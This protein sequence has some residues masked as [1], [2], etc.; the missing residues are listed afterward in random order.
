MIIRPG[1]YETYWQ[2]AANRQEIFFNRLK[3]NAPPW[4]SDPILNTY[5][6]CNTYRASDRVSQYLIRNVIYSGD[7]DAQEVILRTLL[8]KL[9]NKIETWEYLVSK[10]G[11][12]S[13]KN[14]DFELYSSLLNEYR[15]AD[16][17]IYHN[18]YMSC[19]TKAF[20]YDLKHMNHLALVEKMIFKDHLA[21]RITS[22]KS[23][24]QVFKT[25]REYELIGDFMA[26]QLA[27][28][29]NY[30]EAT[31]SDENDFTV[32][33]PGSQR[34]IH[35]CFSDLQGK[36]YTYV[37]KWMQENQ[38]REFTRL[39]LK[40]Q[41][42]W[43]RPLKLIDSQGL[44]C[45]TDKYCRVAFPEIKSNRKK[46]KAHFKPK[47][48]LIQYFYPPKWGINESAQAEGSPLGP[49]LKKSASL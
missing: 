24:A 5:K 6:F 20:G 47:S 35:K 23:F 10:L 39:G 7:Q 8:F 30:S 9:F 43:G 33:G 3:G 34:G 49:C 14:F 45:E 16:G 2:F 28:D 42:L 40:F 48:A 29:I 44:F 41:S 13:T 17:V 26:Y 22:A 38:E 25:L 46:I 32:V 27:T 19:A 1:V 36:D 18:A 15:A 21:S 37:I 12:V 4:T 31:N 11:A